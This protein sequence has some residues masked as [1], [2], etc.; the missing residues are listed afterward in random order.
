MNRARS[1][2]LRR[3]CCWYIVFILMTSIVVGM[4]TCIYVYMYMYGPLGLP[5]SSRGSVGPGAGARL[6]RNGT[7]GV[8]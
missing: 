3:Y 7:N 6:P 4:C 2:G 5:L 1:Y 8:V